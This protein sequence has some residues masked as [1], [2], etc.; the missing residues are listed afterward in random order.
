MKD[1]TQST[2]DAVDSPPSWWRRVWR[3]LQPLIS[4]TS[5]PVAVLFLVSMAFSFVAFGHRDVGH[6]AGSSYAYLFGHWTDFYTYN[7]PTFERNDYF[8]SIY[9]V[10][11]L[12]MAPVKLLVSPGIQNGVNISSWEMLWAK[13]GVMLVFGAT[14]LVMVRIARELFPARQQTQRMVVAAYLLSPFAAF[15]VGVFGRYDIIA[16]LFMLLGL[17]HF[18][19]GNKWRFA[20]F[21]AIAVSFT[22]FAL[23][24]FA[25]L[26]LLRYKRLR[27]LVLLSLTA[28]SIAAL[29][30]AAYWSNPPFHTTVSFLAQ[31]YLKGNGQQ[32]SLQSVILILIL[33]GLFLLWRLPLDPSAL[34]ATAV[35]AGAL[36]YGFMFVAVKWNL[37]WF[38]LLVPLF[39]LTLGYLRRPGRFLLWE[40]GVFVAYIWVAVNRWSHNIDMEMLRRG[41]LRSLL[42]PPH[43]FLSDLYRWAATPWLNVVLT[44]FFLS[45]VL[46]WLL[47]RAE[48]TRAVAPPEDT[49]TVGRG[50][51]ALRAAT[52]L[53][54]WSVPVIAALVMPVSAATM[55]T[56]QAPAYVMEQRPMCGPEHKLPYGQL[57]DGETAQQTFVAQAARLGAVSVMVGT[58]GHQMSGRLLIDVKDAAGTTLGTRD[59]DLTRVPDNSALYV[60]LDS[61]AADS[62]GATYTVTFRTAGVPAT[63]SFSLWGSSDDCDPHGTLTLDGAAQGGDANL[64]EY[65]AR[66]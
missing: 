55:F 40:S 41:S 8:P 49:R 36:A 22:Y 19:R 10:F 1:E 51:W 47:E 29:E 56:P 57:R 33:V 12:W 23:V 5:V 48:A 9:V 53:L 32:G 18:L 42:G 20:F 65:Y 45:P 61:P 3:D 2:V 30:G 62:S 46:F 60:I 64:T 11:A 27:D 15:T 7:Q 24:L 25:P 66:R 35:F 52:P 21:F 39:A 37:A 4:T 14:V 17:L 31:Q 58:W 63:S 13:F 43:L 16:I 28:L 26:L 38:A 50:I 44:V 54:F 59:V 34:G 6:T